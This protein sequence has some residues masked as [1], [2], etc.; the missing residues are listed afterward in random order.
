MTVALSP[1]LGPRHGDS[2]AC[3]SWLPGQ[4]V[5]NRTGK[6]GQHG[7]P[8][9]IPMDT[10]PCPKPRSSAIA[11]VLCPPTK[12]SP[13]SSRSL[14]PQGLPT[15]CLQVPRCHSRQE[16]TDTAVGVLGSS[17]VSL[18]SGICVTGGPVCGRWRVILMSKGRAVYEKRI[19]NKWAVSGPGGRRLRARNR[20]ARLGKM[21]ST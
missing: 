5:Y 9:K 17:D 8:G 10:V 14:G 7:A 21:F 6:A 20:R 1:D 3:A 2:I 19:G 13:C 16:V 12:R 18:D 11:S 15:T 4:I